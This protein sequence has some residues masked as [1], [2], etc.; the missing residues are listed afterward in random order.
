MLLSEI[1]LLPVPRPSGLWVLNVRG[2]SG[3]CSHPVFCVEDDFITAIGV[4]DVLRCHHDAK[5]Q[6]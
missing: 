3:R 4:R 6:S 1:S 5:A 2:G